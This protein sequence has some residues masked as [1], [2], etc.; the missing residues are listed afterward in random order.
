MTLPHQAFLALLSIFLANQASFSEKHV[1]TQ[2]PLLP[3][4]F[5][6]TFR[7]IEACPSL[8]DKVCQ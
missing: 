2:Q 8:C 4:V 3:I 7:Y 1:F 6:V 5:V